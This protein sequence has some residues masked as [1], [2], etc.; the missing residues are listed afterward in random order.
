[1]SE[2]EITLLNMIRNHPNPE[3]ALLIAAVIIQLYLTHPELFV[4][5]QHCL[6]NLN[7]HLPFIIGHS[8]K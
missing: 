1:M 2:N 8:S 7:H 3:D 5:I 4:S 6:D